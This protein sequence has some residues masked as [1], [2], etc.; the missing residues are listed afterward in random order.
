MIRR[1]RRAEE[2]HPSRDR[3]LVSYADFIT[4]LFAFFVVMYAI[5]TLNE[6]KYRV[7]GDSLVYAFRHDR[8]VSPA[9]HGAVP[10]SMST[11]P[12]RVTSSAAE[13]LRRQREQ[14]LVGV[15]DKIRSALEPLVETGQVRMKPS[16]RGLVVEINASVLFAPGQAVLRADSIQALQAV[17]Q[18]LTEV[19]NAINVEGHTD[20]LP[21]ASVQYPSN[22]ELASARASS[23]VRLFAGGG[24]AAQRLSAIG[25]ADNRPVD[26]NETAEGRARNRRVTL[27]ILADPLPEPEIAPPV[28]RHPAAGA[29]AGGHREPSLSHHDI[30]VLLVEDNPDDAEFTLRA[31][32][33]ANI[34]LDVVRVEDGVAAL[35]FVLGTGAQSARA[36]ARLPRLMLLDLD[37]PKLDGLGVLRRLKADVRSK[38]LPVIV[39]TSS[40]RQADVR[41]A[42]RLGANSYIVKPADYAALVAKL[43]DLVRY[44]LQVNEPLRD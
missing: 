7:L 9:S 34:A 26:S 27:L 17:A 20:V 12:V 14:K 22:W 24:V 6:G 28:V 35:E 36:G 15:A 1:R 4:L 43:G 31:L 18:V 40:D 42:Y 39:L 13:Q 37:L 29:S 41:E 33:K 11:P 44:W 19:D 30:D 8:V 3:W 21:I 23:V 16:A 25:Y 38:V 10:S 2:D 5:S 32:R